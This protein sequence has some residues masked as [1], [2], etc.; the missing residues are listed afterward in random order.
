MEKTQER[1]VSALESKD[2]KTLAVVMGPDLEEPE[3]EVELLQ[4]TE[5]NCMMSNM[6]TTAD[7]AR[8]VF[9]EAFR[10]D[11]KVGVVESG[12]EDTSWDVDAVFD[13][14][15][16]CNDLQKFVGFCLWNMKEICD[17]YGYEPGE[18]PYEIEEEEE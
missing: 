14:M 5:L 9:E 17:F 8:Y 10:V 1:L 2:G 3:P 7:T 4:I 16:V 12:E 18:V 6:S 13:N 15:R 11:V